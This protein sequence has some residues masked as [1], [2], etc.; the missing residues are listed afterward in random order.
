MY[1]QPTSPTHVLALANLQLAT[2]GRSYLI[3]WPGSNPELPAVLMISH[4][5]VVP[6]TDTTIKVGSHTI[7]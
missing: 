2:D 4:Y 3:R 6:V 5:D 1:Q 7:G